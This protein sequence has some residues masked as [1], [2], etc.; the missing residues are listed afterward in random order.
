[1]SRRSI[2]SDILIESE[3]ETWVRVWSGHARTSPY[4]ICVQ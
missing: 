2:P 1:M 4:W 3:Y